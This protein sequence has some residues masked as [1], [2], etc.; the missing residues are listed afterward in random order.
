M[1][2]SNLWAYRLAAAVGVT[3]LTLAGRYQALRRPMVDASVSSSALPH[4]DHS[5]KHGGVFFMAPDGFHHLEG[6]LDGREFR[7]YL[8]D[9]FT[10]PLDARRF[11]A[12]VGNHRLEAKPGGKF[13]RI[14]LDDLTTNPSAV[15]AFVRFSGD[16]RDDRFDF[17]FVTARAQRP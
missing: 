14:Q 1:Q 4:A 17:I 12:R 8:Y 6:T 15:T 11:E 10:R 16:G 2:A 5:P 7:F 3:G 9:N 13:L